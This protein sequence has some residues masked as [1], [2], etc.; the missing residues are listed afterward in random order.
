[1]YL[2]WMTST[3]RFTHDN[4]MTHLEDISRVQQDDIDPQ[5]QVHEHSEE[6]RQSEQSR[7]IAI[8]PGETLRER[9]TSIREERNDKDTTLVTKISYIGS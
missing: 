4:I 7:S 3:R 2:R 6:T 5:P 8:A 1:M 9:D